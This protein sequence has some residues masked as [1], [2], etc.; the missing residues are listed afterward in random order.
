MLF[1]FIYWTWHI[2]TQFLLLL[3]DILVTWFCKHTIDTLWKFVMQYMLSLIFQFSFERSLSHLWFLFL[4]YYSKSRILSKSTFFWLFHNR[5]FFQQDD[6][7][8]DNCPLDNCL[9]T[10]HPRQILPRIIVHWMIASQT[11]IP[12]TIAPLDNYPLVNPQLGKLLPDNCTWTISS[13]D[14]WP[15]GQMTP[16]HLPPRTILTRVIVPRQLYHLEIFYG[17]SFCHYLKIILNP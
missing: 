1:L 4:K 9:R 15:A 7:P 5:I 2:S 13:W 14:N 10:I 16:R 12:L 3:T 8:F 6:S 11:I 17:L